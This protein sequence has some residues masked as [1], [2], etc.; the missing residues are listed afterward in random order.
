MIKTA[1]I[2][3]LTQAARS[4]GDDIY[5]RYR[6]YFGINIKTE[7]ISDLVALV[8]LLYPSED[9]DIFS[10][11]YVGYKIPQIGK[12]FD[13]LRMGKNYI[14]NIEIK[15]DSQ[16][17]KI[18]KQLLRNKYYLSAI[19]RKAYY[20][21]FVSSTKMIYF[22]NGHDQ[23]QLIGIPALKSCLHDQELD[24]LENLDKIFNPSRYLVSPFNSTDRFMAN[25]YFLTHQ[26]EQIKNET[27]TLFEESHGP[28]FVSIS[29][30][31]G[32]GKTLLVYDIAKEMT[33]KNKRVLIIHCGNLNF[34]QNKMISEYGWDIIPIKKI[35][36]SNFSLYDAILI[37]ESQR[38]RVDQFHTIAN[39]AKISNIKLIF[40]YDKA[41]VLANWEE[42]IDIEELL[43]ASGLAASH[44]LTDKIRTN[45]SMAN[46]IRALFNK[47]RSYEDSQ[48][49]VELNFFNNLDDAKSYISYIINQGWEVLR[50]TPSQYDREFH[51]LYSHDQ[52][53]T[54]HAVIG[55][56]FDNVAVVIDKFFSYSADGNL[57][58]NER[59]FYKAEKMLFQNITRTVNKLNLIIIDNPEILCRCLTVLHI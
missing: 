3:S 58:Y 11:Y 8:D 20:F 38:M 40:S 6:D 24:I 30:G 37:D 29:G 41:Q 27:L 51:E 22:L 36:A 23:L 2:L 16:E 17:N 25:S 54:S 47:N 34:G 21:S 18:T 49:N 52:S 10:G 59:S 55:Q 56:E 50:L 9:R 4:L 32:V 33:H 46:F 13:L 44:R 53:K 39:M 42:R 5:K 31:A 35:G 57:I 26:Q 7:E 15:K 48:A 45:K 19:D 28:D 12:E 14:V 43:R 1:N